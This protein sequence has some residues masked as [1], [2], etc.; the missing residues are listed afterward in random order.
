MQFIL[1]MSTYNLSFRHF[2]YEIHSLRYLYLKYQK[3]LIFF[4]K[5][6][7]LK[8]SYYIKHSIVV[9]FND[10]LK[11]QLRKDILNFNF[12]LMNFV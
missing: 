2:N 9:Y 11:I 5:Y 8:N 7:L 12:F 4:T 3:V 6:F 10:N 1:V